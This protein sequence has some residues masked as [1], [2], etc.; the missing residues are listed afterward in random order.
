MKL[1]KKLIIT[2]M[3]ILIFIHIIYAMYNISYA[4]YGS[5]DWSNSYIGQEKRQW[6]INEGFGEWN[7]SMHANFACYVFNN[8]YCI[9]PG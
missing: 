4:G 5:G 9:Q 8:I 1:L 3:I 2:T 6:D 7:Y